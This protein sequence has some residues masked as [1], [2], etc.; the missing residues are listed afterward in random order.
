MKGWAFQVIQDP[1]Y[2]LSDVSG[3]ENACD[4]SGLFSS[5]RSCPPV[6]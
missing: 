3:W 5:R 4:G 6:E 2:P 1:I